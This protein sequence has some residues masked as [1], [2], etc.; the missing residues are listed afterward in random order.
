MGNSESIEGAFCRD[1]EM[2]HHGVDGAA[3][4]NAQPA[5]KKHLVISSRG[6]LGMIQIESHHSCTDLRV[7]ISEE[8]DED[9]L[10]PQGEDTIS[11]SIQSA[12]HGNK[13]AELWLRISLDAALC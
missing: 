9:M 8:F 12:F 5:P 2:Y 10:P 7:L 3:P 13:S 4:H 1:G 11:K 6:Y